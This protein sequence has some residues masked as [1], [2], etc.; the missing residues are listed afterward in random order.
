[1]EWREKLEGKRERSGETRETKGKRIGTALNALNALNALKVPEDRQTE[2]E[3]GAVEAVFGEADSFAL[4]L[5]DGRVCK[6]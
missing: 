2:E 5:D 1:M 3:C 6:S 4:D